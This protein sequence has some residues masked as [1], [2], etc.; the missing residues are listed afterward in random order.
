M[1]ARKP[2][3]TVVI[4]TY[5]WSGV[6]R[7]AIR[8]AMLQTLQD[9]EILVVGDGCTDDSES[10]VAS[11]NDPRIRWHNLERNYGSQWMANNYANEHA[12]GDWIAYLGHDDIWYPTHLEAVLRTAAREQADVVTSTMILYWPE[13]T[14]GRSIA[15]L[16]ATGSYTQHDFVPPSAFAHSRAMYGD[17]VMW[18][19]STKSAL[20]IDVAFINELAIKGRKFAQT[21]ELTVFKFNAAWRRDAYKLRPTDEQERM[22]ARIERGGDFRQDELL[23][24]LQAVVSGRFSAI[25]APPIAGIAEGEIVRRN[26]RHK[27]S[28]PRFDSKSLV[29]VERPVRFE[30]ES[31]E[32]PFEWHGLEHG[33]RGSFRWS[34]PSRVATIDLPV[35]CDRD[36]RV[37]IDSMSLLPALAQNI[38]LSVH[39]NPLDVRVERR[40]GRYLLETIVRRSDVDPGRDFGITMDT[41]GVV[42]PCDLGMGKDE[43]WLGIGVFAVALEPL[44]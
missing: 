24:T 32:M 34:G 17:V 44:G 33:E 6:L 11:F 14:G 35:L 18:R 3:I 5:N 15:G 38:Q 8:S 37:R 36:L 19:D 27:G 21:R 40:E 28:D 16:F 2:A 26:R 7:C 10:V 42:R 25:A 41:G 23:E 9:F 12:R 22:L 30:M 13:S 1:V 31:Q 39:G 43:R 20:P 4:P 29:R